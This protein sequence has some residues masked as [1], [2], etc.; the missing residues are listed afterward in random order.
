MTDFNYDELDSGI[1]ETVRWL[2]DRGYDTTDSGDGVSKGGT[3]QA[4]T[5]LNFPHVVIRIVPNKMIH[6]SVRLWETLVEHGIDFEPK[7]PGYDPGIEV[8]YSP[9]D[10]VATIML[11]EIDDKLMGLGG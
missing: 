9:L 8:N 5:M 7:N 10:G 11:L 4:S 6:E 3:E 1:R 2:R